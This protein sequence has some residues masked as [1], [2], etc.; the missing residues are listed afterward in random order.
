MA[1]APTALPDALKDPALFRQ[2]AYIDGAWVAHPAGA[3]TD[4]TNPAT[5][6]LIA[7]VPK[8]GR[9]EATRSVEVAEQAFRSWSKRTAK[10]RSQIIRRWFDLMTEHEDDLAL[11]LTLE[12]GKP[13]PEALAEVRYGAAFT[14]FYAEEA[15]RVYGDVVPAHFTDRRI[16]VAKQPIGVVAAITPWNFPNAM[17]LRKVAPAL[18]AG[19]TVVCKP[20]PQ[21]PL[22]ALALC[23]LAERAGLPAGCFNVVTGNEV[24]IGGV[25]TSHDAVR[26]VTFTGSTQVGKLL[27]EQSARTVKKTSMELG[28][29]A[30]FIVF[31][32]ADIDR[33]VEG[34]IASKYRNTGQTCVCTN[35]ILVQNSVYAAFTQKLSAAVAKLKVGHGTEDGA[36]IGPLIDAQAL[37]KVEGHVADALAKGAKIG[38]GGNRHAL[39]GTFYE[40]TVLIDAEPDMRI[41]R[42]ET[43]GPVAP[44]FRFRTEEEAVEMANDTNYGL[45]AYVYSRD[46][47]RC[48]RVGEAL[49]FGIVGINEALLSV[50]VAPFGGVK[51]SGIGREG[52]KWGL[53]EFLEPKYMTFGGLDGE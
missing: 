32:D 2:Q 9:E 44:V 35:R 48:W 16:V 41:A 30:P 5:G 15:K 17:I 13:L 19:C 46:V 50:E 43:F 34:A 31:D 10:E 4:V 11:L 53:E 24:E 33:A 39:G 20:A 36:Q 25:Y 14:E 40:P 29:N 47:G 49:D 7:Q 37:E 38:T 21:T 3:V 6:D 22:S 52:G 1:D 51:E 42:E 28:G 45:A 12:Q 18:A 23:E 8:L 26:V 27:M